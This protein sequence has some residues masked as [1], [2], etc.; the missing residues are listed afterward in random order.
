[1]QI[2]VKSL[3]TF[4]QIKCTQLYFYKMHCR[5]VCF[6]APVIEKE[7]KNHIDLNNEYNKRS[8][9]FVLLQSEWIC[10]YHKLSTAETTVTKYFLGIE[11]EELK[12]SE[13]KCYKFVRIWWDWTDLFWGLPE[14]KSRLVQ[15]GQ[16]ILAHLDQPS[17]LWQGF[18]CSQNAYQTFYYVFLPSFS[19]PLLTGPCGKFWSIIWE[20]NYYL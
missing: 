5:H 1:M 6:L 19:A 9:L 15:H 14:E 20:L 18:F 4:K 12:K 2:I 8:K 10:D 17:R 7:F 11:E 3:S 13:V 16:L